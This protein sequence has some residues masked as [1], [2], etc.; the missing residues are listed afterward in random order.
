M[1]ITGGNAARRLLKVPK[2]LERPSDAGLGQA[3]NL[4]FPG[5]LRRRRE[6]ARIVRG[7][8]RVEPGMFEPRRGLG[9]VRGEISEARGIHPAKR[10]GDPECQ[11]SRADAGRFYGGRA[12]GSKRRPV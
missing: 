2:G 1:R 9:V 11:S 12:I 8:R 7:Q 3:G 4:Q 6:G 5:G 10:G